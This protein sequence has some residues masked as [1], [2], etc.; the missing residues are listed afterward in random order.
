MEYSYRF[1][2]YPNKEQEK[3][4]QKNFGCCGRRTQHRFRANFR[5]WM[6]LSKASTDG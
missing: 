6:K 4:I 5:Y 3:Q 2:I 1:R